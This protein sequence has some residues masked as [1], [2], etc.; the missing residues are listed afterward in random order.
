M[1]KGYTYDRES[2]E[3]TIYH[4]KEFIRLLASSPA[5]EKIHVIAHSR[6][7]D[8]AASALRELLI[9][10]KAAGINPQKKFKIGNLVVAAPDL[11]FDVV[12]QR[13]AAERFLLIA[14]RLTVYVSEGDSAIALAGILFTSRRRLGQLRAE[15]FTAEQKKIL[16]KIRRTQF[17]DVRV[18]QGGHS[19][20]RQDPS[21]SS[22][23]ILVLRD[24]R[25][26]GSAHGRPLIERIPNYWELHEGYPGPPQ[27]ADQSP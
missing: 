14:E 26:P 6:G 3:F 9:E 10:A 13:F 20:F 27:K 5:L 2:G 11:D 15:D 21:A 24:N 18:E 22:D 8:V 19:Y 12:T 23:L 7:T 16:E 17:I 1:L 4:L 25:P